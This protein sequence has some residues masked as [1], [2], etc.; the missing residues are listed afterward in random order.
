MEGFVK[1]H[2]VDFQRRADSDTNLITI[3]HYCRRY[4]KVVGLY[5]SLDN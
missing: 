5:Y 2:R 3:F 1:H 4:K